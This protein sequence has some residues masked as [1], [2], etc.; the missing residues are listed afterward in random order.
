MAEAA[1]RKTT[2]CDEAGEMGGI[3]G[4]LE[5]SNRAGASVLHKSR[6]CPESFSTHK[7]GDG[8]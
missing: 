3:G 1:L 6:T 7:G 2:A 5:Q 4:G 8:D